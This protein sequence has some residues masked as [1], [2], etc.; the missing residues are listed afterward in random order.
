MF[1][2]L[3]DRFWPYSKSSKSP[4]PIPSTPK[5]AILWGSDLQLCGTVSP[6]NCAANYTRGDKSIPTV[7][8]SGLLHRPQTGG[9]KIA[10]FGIFSFWL[11]WP[12]FAYAILNMARNR[13]GSA[14]NIF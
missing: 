7:W 6:E 9:A 3:P 11:N 10:I 4:G 12:I 8:G 2:A 14:Q 5:I 1:R 13:S